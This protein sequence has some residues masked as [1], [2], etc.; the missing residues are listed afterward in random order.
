MKKIIS[1]LLALLMMFSLVSVAFAADDSS[2]DIGTTEN[3]ETTAPSEEDDAE[4]IIPD[5]GEYDWILDLPF[6]TVGPALKFAKIA[7]KLV[8]VYLKVAKIFGLVEKDMEDYIIEA[9]LG[10]IENAENG[11]AEEEVTDPSDE[12]VAPEE[13]P[14]AA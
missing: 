6:W 4:S 10:L 13:I 11:G 3:T 1:L 14:D 5:L 7:L 12:S 2:E 8:T 9:I